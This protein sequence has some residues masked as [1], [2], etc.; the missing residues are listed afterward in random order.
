M[1]AEIVLDIEKFISIHTDVSPIDAILHFCEK[2]DIEPESMA[3]IISGSLKERVMLEAK[4]QRLMKDNS[5]TRSL[6]DR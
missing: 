4:Y 6:L 5:V 3:R 1:T 2:H